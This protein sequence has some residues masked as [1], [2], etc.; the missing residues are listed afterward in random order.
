MNNVNFTGTYIRPATVYKNSEPVRAAVI[1][2]GKSDVKSVQRVAD[3]WDSWITNL[4]TAKFYEPQMPKDKKFYALSTQSSDFQKVKPSEVLAFFEVDDN[5]AKYTL[6][7]LDVNPRYRKNPNIVGKKRKGI[8]KIGQACVEFVRSK[9]ATKK[10]TDLYA[11]DGAKSFYERL[12]CKK[13][14]N[15]SNNRYLI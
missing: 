8:S 2:L 3:R 11:I 12:G 4:I 13:V 5:G 6:E 15:E 9:F 7:Y 14:P 10:E 1:E